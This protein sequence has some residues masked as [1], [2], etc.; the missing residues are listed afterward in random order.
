M[1]TLTACSNENQEKQQDDESAAVRH[2]Y[3][4]LS[5]HAFL[6][7]C[8]QP[9]FSSCSLHTDMRMHAPTRRAFAQSASGVVVV[10]QVQRCSRPAV[11]HPGGYQLHQLFNIEQAGR[12]DVDD[13]LPVC[14]M[15]V[16]C[17][18]VDLF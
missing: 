9:S 7:P 18:L 11:P 10:L 6:A 2:V 5:T 1:M 13:G 8:L 12:D 17:N 14:Q 16:L 15:Y 4:A 3:A